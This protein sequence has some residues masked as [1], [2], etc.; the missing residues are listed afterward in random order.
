MFFKVISGNFFRSFSTLTTTHVTRRRPVW[1]IKQ[2]YYHKLWNLLTSKKWDEFNQTLQLM[3]EKGLNND[4]VTYT[5][6]AHYFILNPYVAVE[7]CYLVIEEMKRALIHPAVIRMNENLI[8]SYFELEEIG[9]E[10]PKLL[11]QNFTKMIF[12]TSIKLNRVRRHNLKRQLL[13]KDPEDVMKLTDKDVEKMLIEEHNSNLITPFMAIDEIHDDPIEVN[14]EKFKP[15]KP[16]KLDF[17]SLYS[18]Q[19]YDSE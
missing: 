12:Q 5:L 19:H 1:K 15:I 2:T 16:K 18:L 14:P 8:N 17:I 13:L 7:N 3:R 4:E 6:K 11:W 9:C 10:P